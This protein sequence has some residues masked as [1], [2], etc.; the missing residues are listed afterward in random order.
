MW[1]IKCR[2]QDSPDQERRSQIMSKPDETIAKILEAHTPDVQLL[3]EKLRQLVHAACPALEEEGKLGWKNITYKRN[4]VVV[5]ISPYKAHVNLGFYKGASLDD[6]DGILEGT[7]KGLRHVKISKPEDIR[8]EYLTGLIQQ[9][10]QLDA[11]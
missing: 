1:R 2:I 8:T 9:A 7:G 6:A 3:V 5:A 10:N 4:R 11:D